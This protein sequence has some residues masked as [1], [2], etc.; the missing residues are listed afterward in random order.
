MRTR[1]TIARQP[2]GIKVMTRVGM[3]GTGELVKQLGVRDNI[4]G[5]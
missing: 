3:Y 4:N 1:E 2:S 5:R